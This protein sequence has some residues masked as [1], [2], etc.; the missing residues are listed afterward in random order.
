M[1]TTAWCT[2][3]SP[4]WSVP[5]SGANQS[6]APCTSIKYSAVQ[7]FPAIHCCS[8]V[9]PCNTL[10]QC[11]ASLQCLAAVQCSQSSAQC[12]MT[13]C[14]VLGLES[15]AQSHSLVCS[16]L[17]CF[18]LHCNGLQCSA[19]NYTAQ[20]YTTSHSTALCPALLKIGNAL[21][22]NGSIFSEMAYFAIF[23]C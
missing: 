5:G 16:A 13:G 14:P 10:L 15:I 1:C 21:H 20:K 11:S 22:T 4:D 6:T 18:A 19:L 3:W 17:H 9:L 12:C 7:C 23:G 2:G 8:A